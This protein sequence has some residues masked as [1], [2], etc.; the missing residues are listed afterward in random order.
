MIDPIDF[1]KAERVLLTYFRETSL[2]RWSRR[3]AL[4]GVLIVISRVFLGLSLR[5]NDVA[6]ELVAS[7]LLLWRACAT[8]WRARR[9]MPVYRG[10]FAKYEARIKDLSERPSAPEAGPASADPPPPPR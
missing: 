8:L 9:V 1:T 4:D 7:G 2:A 3:V 6:R 5:Q 10:I